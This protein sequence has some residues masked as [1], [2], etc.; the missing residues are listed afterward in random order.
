MEVAGA[1]RRWRFQFRCR[2]SR[3]ESAVAQLFSLG[4]V[5]RMTA[6]IIL[7]LSCVSVL[8][9][10]TGIQVASAVSTNAETGA[11]YTTETFTRSGQTNLISLTEDG[12]R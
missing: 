11:I 12:G 8:A 1:N 4:L 10:D 3:R 2:G 6:F 9:A 7:L 5:P